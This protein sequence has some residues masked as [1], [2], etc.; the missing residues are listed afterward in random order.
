MT[1]EIAVRDVP[2]QIMLTERATLRAD[3]L[4]MWIGQALGRQHGV[5]TDADD[6]PGASVVIY[7]ELVT[8][9]QEGE[10][11]ACTPVSRATAESCGLPT[12]VEP[13]HREVYTSITRA[14]VAYPEILEAYTAVE[15]WIRDEGGTV[16][17]SPREVYFGDWH[18]AGDDEPVVDIA[19]P[20]A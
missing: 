8:V 4:P 17:G 16:V 12:R 15:N 11:E 2:E 3:A 13:A 6:E 18:A 7:H 9:E 14:Q 10:V 19:Y 20:V 1:Y 5:V